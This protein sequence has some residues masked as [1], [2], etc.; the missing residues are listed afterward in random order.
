VDLQPGQP[1]CVYGGSVVT[2]SEV[3]AAQEAQLRVQPGRQ[4]R[5]IVKS[6]LFDLPSFGQIGNARCLVADGAPIRSRQPDPSVPPHDVISRYFGALAN[7][8][9]PGQDANLV[10]L[11]FVGHGACGASAQLQL[12]GAD[13]KLTPL[14]G[15]DADLLLPLLVLVTN[16]PV[17]AGEELLLCYGKDYF[18]TIAAVSAS[19]VRCAPRYPPPHTDLIPA[20]VLSSGCCSMGGGAPRRRSTL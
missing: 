7:A 19:A 8:P 17:P 1:I 10:A 18:K 12:R 13:G 6:H 20:R 14:T 3:N 2:L 15:A 4:G 11:E 16:A 9:S 5:P